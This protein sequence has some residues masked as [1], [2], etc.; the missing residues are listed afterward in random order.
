MNTRGLINMPIMCGCVG[1]T[2][3]L[4]AAGVPPG[5]EPPAA[6]HERHL[7]LLLQHRAVALREAAGGRAALAAGRCQQV[8]R[9]PGRSEPARR[10]H[11]L[12]A[13]RAAAGPQ[14]AAA[15]ARGGS[16][17]RGPGRLC[18]GQVQGWLAGLRLRR[19]GCAAEPSAHDVHLALEPARFFG[20]GSRV[21]AAASARHAPWPAG[22]GPGRDGRDQAAGSEVA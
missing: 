6:A 7:V 20:Q 15:G 10:A 8:Q 3:R 16:G 17:R 21:H 12:V 18:A 1:Q 13:V 14:S 4:A 9:Q 2:A 22:Q 11:G 5:L 19:P